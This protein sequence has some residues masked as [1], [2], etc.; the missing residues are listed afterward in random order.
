MLHSSLAGGGWLLSPLGGGAVAEAVDSSQDGEVEERSGG[1]EE[2]HGHAQPIGVEVVPGGA[3]LSDGGER[4]DSDDQAESVERGE[5]GAD[6]LQDGEGEGGPGDESTGAVELR[7]QVFPGGVPG[8]DRSGCGGFLH[9]AVFYFK[10]SFAHFKTRLRPFKNRP[11]ALSNPR[12]SAL[13]TRLRA[14]KPRGCVHCK[15]RS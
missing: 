3:G 5:E 8:L 11:R 1:S 6:A 7:G 14:C 12:R 13:E 10:P 2:D 4:A 15:N 9:N